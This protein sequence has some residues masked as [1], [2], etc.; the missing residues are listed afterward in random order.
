MHKKVFLMYT[1]KVQCVQKSSHQTQIFDKNVSPLFLKK[2]STF[3]NIVLNFKRCSC[4]SKNKTSKMF[5]VLR[6]VCEFQKMIVF[7]KHARNFKK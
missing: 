1:K 4:F 3:S 7:S 2:C 5:T 6:N